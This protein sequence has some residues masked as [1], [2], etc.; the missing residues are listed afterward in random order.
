[1]SADY[2][3]E[4]DK[5]PRRL[6]ITGVAR[7]VTEE[8]EPYVQGIWYDRFLL[9]G[10]DEGEDDDS[11]EEKDGDDHAEGGDSGTPEASQKPDF[12]QNGMAPGKLANRTADRSVDGEDPDFGS[13]DLPSSSSSEY[14]LLEF[15]ST[16][17]SKAEDLDN[18]RDGH[19]EGTDGH[20]GGIMSREIGK[21]KRGRNMNRGTLLG[22]SSDVGDEALEI[23]EAAEIVL[24]PG[25]TL[26][27]DAVDEE[28]SEQRQRSLEIG[29]C[30]Y[31]LEI[32]SIQLDTGPGMQV[33]EISDE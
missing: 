5:P 30:F 7:R 24:P 12:P 2:L 32:V 14:S 6:T 9:A 8:E 19:R 16:S 15:P 10:G 23:E 13:S 31:K 29:T 33:E 17:G 4:I 20:E 3:S 18:G 26:E 27:G 11:E 22:S 25:A 1:M 28:W 21:R